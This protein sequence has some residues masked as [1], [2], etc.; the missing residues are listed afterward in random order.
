[1]KG[2]KK[3]ASL[4]LAAVLAAGICMP[5]YAAGGESTLTIKTT[6]GHTYKVY[7][8][9]TGDVSGVADGSGTVAN[10]KAGANLKKDTTAEQFV[11][12]IKDK[13]DAE[14]GDTAFSYVD[15][16]PVATV[17]GTGQSVETTVA[18]G[19]YLVTDTWTG[20]EVT[21]G[22]DTMSRYMVAVVG[23]TT[24]TP[25]TSTPSIDKKIID[26]DA[27]AAIDGAPQ[28]TDTAA[29]G[30][31][32][33]YEV[34]GQVPNMD[35]Y[36]YYYY[37]VHDTMSE[38]LTLNQ[39]SFVVTI[40]GK[41]LVKDTDY[42][43]YFDAAT[44]SFELALKDL[45]AL[46][47]ASDNDIKV[48]SAISVKYTAT[49]NDQA[50]IGV[51]PNTNTAKLEYSNNP[52]SSEKNDIEDKPGLPKPGTATGE[53][54]NLITKTYVTQLT[55]IK[56]DDKGNRLEGA[57]FTL[58]GENLNKVIINIQGT[59]RLATGGETGEYYKLVDGTYTTTAPSAAE[60]GQEGY[61]KDKYVTLTPDY[62]RVTK[63]TTSTEATGSPKQ[64]TAEVTADGTLVFTGLN[65]GDYVLKETK[66][67]EGYNTIGDITF[68]ISATQTG[69]T[70]TA[71]GKITWASSN[72]SISLDAANG[73]FSTTIVNKS[74]SVLPSTG[75]MGTM[76]FYAV[77]AVLVIGAA[78]LLVVK[79]RSQTK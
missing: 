73:V 52:G 55:I 57:E 56:T 32:I 28:K 72:P 74:G 75:G 53:G 78:I 30:D 10:V 31:V 24:M 51:D 37:V 36:K 14:L 11:D 26:T 25:K 54:P 49:V 19:Y 47:N 6:A 71:G 48:G 9:L 50:S 63:A 23:N 22:S 69:A 46:V 35:G 4:L 7:Q 66:T 17:E 41:T 68:T 64:I 67:P 62:V 15:G 29:I 42:Y 2:L 18:D 79:R 59:F 16:K 12:A 1:M 5:A 77:G 3:L 8:L 40:G 45:K 20:G 60:E 58:V 33:E 39:N 13:T 76:V 43:V 44:N 61:N 27:N 21:D 38:G 70:G 65:A 34:T